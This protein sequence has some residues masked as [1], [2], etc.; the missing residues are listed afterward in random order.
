[1]NRLLLA[2]AIVFSCLGIQPLDAEEHDNGAA[3]EERH[4]A[5]HETHAE[6]EHS[7]EE[8]R[9]VAEAH[10][11]RLLHAWTRATSGDTAL[12]FVEI[13]NTSGGAVSIAGGEADIAA[14]VALVGF[15]MREG[16]GRYEALPPVPVKAG[17][18][19][20]L[21]PNGL[22]LRLEGLDRPL[23]EGEE[24]EMEILFDIGHVEAHVQVEDADA[25]Q[26]SHAGHQH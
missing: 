20:V 4:E 15:R 8:A 7:E 13:E 5:G 16:E 2:A 12:V 9:H 10:G 26:H 6:D 24:F 17:G 22:A 11:V 18:E 1:M 21:A 19:M 3:G 14:S 23:T 25:R